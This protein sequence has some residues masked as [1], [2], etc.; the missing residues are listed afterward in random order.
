MSS[1]SPTHTYRTVSAA[2][3]EGRLENV[4]QRQKE[5]AALH[6]SVKKSSS[7]LINALNQDLHTTDESAT[8]ELQLTLDSI[9]HLYDGLNFPASLANERSIKQG[10]SLVDNLVPLGPTLIDPAPHAPVAS[11]LIPL[12]AAVAAGSTVVALAHSSVPAV[13]DVLRQVL[14]EG[15][16]IEAVGLTD[17]DSANTRQQLGLKPWGVAVLQNVREHARIAKLVS[18]ANPLVR[19]LSPPSGICAVFIDR[20]VQDIAAAASHLHHSVL[21]T[22]RHHPLRLP[23]LCF[24]DEAIIGDLEAL[25]LSAGSGS[26]EPLQY[27]DDDD[28]T[29]ALYKQLK[30]VFPS[31]SKK[32]SIGTSLSLSP[33][34][35]LKRSDPITAE[36]IR[37]VAQSIVDCHSGILLIPTRSLDHGIDLL[38]KVND[39]MPSQATYVFGESK[40]SFYVAAFSNT[41]QVF[42]NAIPPCSL[43]A[44][45]PNSASVSNRVLYSREDFSVN[46]PVSQVS[47]RSA[48]AVKIDS[49]P[50]W[51]LTSHT[52]RLGK[53]KQPKG[54]RLSYFERGLILGLALS[55]VAISGLSVGVHRAGQVYFRR[56]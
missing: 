31:L 37:L 25:L 8:E 54:G 44:V 35:A 4:L 14:R 3:T 6:S 1:A 11:T 27:D 28:K 12:A 26:I 22:P 9:R 53:I 23:R 24:V 17:N 15:I 21:T 39:K 13:N 46:K 7:R 36:A 34:V 38:N 18:Q 32:T 52:L 2:W 55:L 29:Q 51:S 56:T 10:A 30:S 43:I 41:V 49:K 45:A 40:P 5:L 20:S 16:D 50:V 47:L 33:V 48:T 19:S 42:I